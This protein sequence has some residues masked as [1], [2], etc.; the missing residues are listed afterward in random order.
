MEKQCTHSL[1]SSNWHFSNTILEPLD[2][3]NFCNSSW[4]YQVQ[5]GCSTHFQGSER[6]PSQPTQTLSSTMRGLGHTNVETAVDICVLLPHRQLLVSHLMNLE[7]FTL[8]LGRQDRRS[9]PQLFLWAGSSRFDQR[10]LTITRVWSRK[11]IYWVYEWAAMY[12]WPGI[13]LI[14]ENALWSRKPKASTWIY[15]WKAAW[16]HK[17]DH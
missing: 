10:I 7:V 2:P 3:V 6:K 1:K 11:E 15:P 12:P 8:S 9:R 4:P 5:A 17:G 16:D 13:L 14:P